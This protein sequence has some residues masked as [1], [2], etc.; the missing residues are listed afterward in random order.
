[1]EIRLLP[2]RISSLTLSHKATHKY[3]LYMYVPRAHDKTA[4]EE[5]RATPIDARNHRQNMSRLL[6]IALM[7]LDKLTCSA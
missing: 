5:E 2:R 1:M 4:E 3:A 6:K 7:F